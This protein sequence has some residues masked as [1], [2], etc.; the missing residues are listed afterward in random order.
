MTRPVPFCWYELMTSDVRAAADFYGKV[1]G[2]RLSDR[3][4]QS[5]SD[6]RMI[7]RNDG[8]AIGGALQ[9][10]GDMLA[11]G[12]RPAWVP[13]LAVADIEASLPAMQA[14]G[15]RVLM[16]RTDIAQGSFAMLADPQGAPFYLM[17]PKPPAD[18]PDA[19]SD[20]FKADGVQHARWNEL[21]TSNADAAKAFY[22][23]HFGFEFNTSMPMG[24]LGE[25]AFI[26]F[27]GQQLGAIMPLIDK[28]RLP[29]WLVY[30]GV[31]SAMAAR[32]V[33]ES[34]GGQV[35]MGPHEVPGGD[36]VVVATDPCGAVFGVV[37][38]KGE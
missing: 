18:R 29:S 25:Y 36:W 10:T 32:N 28:Q 38:P 5:V 31:P 12:A 11:Q 33:I 4:P 19:R 21:A 2:W 13:Y 34:A 3:D 35:I 9:L 22:A 23:R 6:Y 26:D 30:F 15:G 1:I 27:A 24:D 8:G 7:L 17:Q 37:G 20:A 14:E 16:P